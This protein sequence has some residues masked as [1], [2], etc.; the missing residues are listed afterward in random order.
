MPIK[1]IWHGWTDPDQADAYQTL[2]HD[3]VFPGI[4]AMEIPGFR[5]I[6]LLRRDLGEEVEFVTIMT[7]DSLENVIDFQGLDY[8][9]AYVPEAARQVL[10]RW[11]P[12]SAHYQSV[13][14]PITRTE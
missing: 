9:E 10:K 7:F 2:L 6:E 14:L 5:G 8:E 1:R 12:T 11:D 4:E 13:A 3:D